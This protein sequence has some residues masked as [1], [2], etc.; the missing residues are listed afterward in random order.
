MTSYKYNPELKS[1]HLEVFIC[2]IISVNINLDKWN[3][4]NTHDHTL[5]VIKN[6]KENITDLDIHC[7]L[8]C[9]QQA[10]VWWSAVFTVTYLL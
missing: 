5:K 4:N 8:F 9:L 7:C 2:H 10:K 3:A 6:T 1:L